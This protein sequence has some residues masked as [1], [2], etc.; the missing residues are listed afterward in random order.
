VRNKLTG[1][2]KIDDGLFIRKMKMKFI[3]FFGGFYFP[4][5]KLDL[6][7]YVCLC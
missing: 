6:L 4:S 3:L 5:K 2:I 1:G 7:L